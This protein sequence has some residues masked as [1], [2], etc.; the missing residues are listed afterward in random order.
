MENIEGV[1]VA[2]NT[3]S[4]PSPEI[5]AK[6]QKLREEFAVRAEMERRRQLGQQ[7]LE[8]T[9]KALK[10]PSQAKGG[11]TKFLEPSVEKG[12]MYH[13][14][15]SNVK[16]FKPREIQAYGGPD[17]VYLTPIPNVA[18]KFAERKQ[19][20]KAFGDPLGVGEKI[21]K[22]ANVMPLH[23]QVTNPFDVEK[24][25]HYEAL[26][27]YLNANPPK[28]KGEFAPHANLD[29]FKKEQLARALLNA[30]H[31]HKRA[32]EK[33]TN[34]QELE[35]ADIQDAI[36]KMGHD[37]FY[38][39]ELGA[40]NLGVF[41]PRKIKSAIGNRGTYDINNPDITKAKGGQVDM[42]TMR[43]ALAMKKK[44]AHLAIGGQGPRNWLKGSVEQTI[45]GLKS[46]LR[47]PEH[48]ADLE[49]TANDPQ[50]VARE[51]AQ[52]RIR[53]HHHEVAINQW[54]DR[55]LTNYI[56]KQMATHNDPI[57]KL[58]EEGI[59]HIPTEQVGINRYKA[60]DV[61]RTLGGEKL[62][63]SP[64]AEAWEDATD[65][66][67]GRTKV[68]NIG[69]L[70]DQYREPWHE[71]ADPETPLY[72]PNDNM[73]ASYLGFDH[74]VDIL[75]EDLEQGR[76][77][78]EQLSKVSIEHAVRR[79][80][81]Y[82]QERKK[83]MAET[84]LKATEGMPV[85]KEYPEGYKWIELAPEPEDV[86]RKKHE[87]YVRK[88][89]PDIEKYDPWGFE[90]YVKDS[91]NSSRV[92]DQQKLAEALK[93][94]GDTMGHC[95]GGYC[96]DVASGKTRI[97]SLRDAKNEP[98][99]TIEVKPPSVSEAINKLPAEERS[100]M[101][102]AVK[103]QHFNGVMPSSRNEDKYWNLIDQA[104]INKYGNPAPRI[105]QIKGKG[106]AKPKKDYI[107]YVQDFVKSGNWSDVGDLKNAE[108]REPAGFLKSYLEENK[109]PHDKY[110]TEQEHNA[111]ES[112]YL[113][114]QLKPEQKAK[115]GITHAHHLDIEE[116]A[117]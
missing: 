74:I 76:I 84:A 47:S 77:R 12:V 54:V 8:E 19:S 116:R 83:K 65:V 26:V 35:Q 4:R 115:G 68:K 75:K 109:I 3:P 82:D 33:S 50:S 99:V 13:G 10:L 102:Q 58:A 94:E 101:A 93:Y 88:D 32:K 112:N 1:T 34:Y 21:S 31:S 38:T 42:D 46:K 89:F 113:L 98:H 114:N 55:N 80:H 25:E 92:V 43:Y 105:N 97:F 2:D 86:L 16:K 7:N 70:S 17:A 23:A 45:E 63:K 96:P 66:V 64:E 57:R 56:K 106:N 28:L 110:M 5:L 79:A 67:M 11:L 15:R 24:P 72:Y 73:H 44:P 62:A 100:A 71:K 48:V 6:L 27:S 36:K 29:W 20:H 61:R 14:T 69:S 60:D 117:L 30:S 49:I 40:K 95:V 107:P 51:G 108:M 18:N 53:Q 90:Q 78:P 81:E 22:G 87:E 111:H 103:D 91:M 9:I 41:D 104:Y 37:A 52:A 85:H 59:I 39:Y